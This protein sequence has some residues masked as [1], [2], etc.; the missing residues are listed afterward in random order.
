LI[1]VG[2]VKIEPS[3]KSTPKSS[4]A[5]IKTTEPSIAI[6][7]KAGASCTFFLDPQL[8]WSAG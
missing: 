4:P 6:A 3:Q 8:H 2:V 1:D 5:P 7:G